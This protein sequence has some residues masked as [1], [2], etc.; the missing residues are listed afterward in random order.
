MASSL[1]VIPWSPD[2]SKAV[3]KMEENPRAEGG[4]WALVLKSLLSP[5]P[6]R[7]LD[8]VYTSLGNVFEKQANHAAYALGMGPHIVAGKIKAYFRSGEERVERLELL[9]I[10]V[11]LQLEKRCLKLIKYALPAESVKVQ[12]QAF[13][14]IVDVV[15]LFPGV[16][17]LFPFVKCLDG[18]TSENAISTLWDRS[19]ECPDKDRKFWQVFAE[20][21][22]TES[23]ISTIVEGSSFSDLSNCQ[24]EGLSVVEQLLVQHDCSD[25][26]YSSA[27]CLR[28]LGGILAFPQFWQDMGKYA[29]NSPREPEPPFDYEGV[30]FLATNLLTGVLG[31]FNKLDRDDWAKQLW[32]ES[33]TKLLQL[34]R[35]PLAGELLS[36]SSACATSSFEEISPTVRKN[37]ELTLAVACDSGT[38]GAP[39]TNHDTSLAD[40]HYNNDSITSVHTGTSDREDTQDPDP[41]HEDCDDARSADSAEMS[42]QNGI[43]ISPALEDGF[44][45][46]DDIA[47]YL[48]FKSDIG[49]RSKSNGGPDLVNARKIII[50]GASTLDSTPHPS[51]EALR[52][53]AEQQKAVLYDRRRDFGDDHLDTLEAM[54]HLAYTHY[55]LGEYMAARD[56]Q[57]V[58]L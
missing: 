7:T 52:K 11:P 50:T 44:E 1:A 55:D 56:L 12:H 28:Y 40:L 54:E 3:A 21:C 22:L 37:A 45:S 43:D 48:D 23:D 26:Q 57:A 10:S 18:E 49:Q 46:Q 5:S 58:V 24:Q 35:R 31:W 20:T 19:S 33:F 53:V 4:R 6:G 8:Q 30:D 14:E 47:D 51:L 17:S 38:T 34:L 41:D 13:K 16:R 36:H 32:Y 39:D 25:S 27:L 42:S 15:T 2:S 9:R 29:S